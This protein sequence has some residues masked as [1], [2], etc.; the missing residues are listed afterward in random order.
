MLRICVVCGVVC[1][2]CDLRLVCGF[3]LGFDLD[4]LDKLSGLLLPILEL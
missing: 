2:L 3:D 1:G 4:L